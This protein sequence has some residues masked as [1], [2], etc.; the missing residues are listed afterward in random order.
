MKVLVAEPDDCTGCRYCQLW[1]SIQHYG[2]LNPF[3]SSVRIIPFEDEG[4]YVP[5]ICQQCEEAYCRVV[6]P[7]KAI[8]RNVATGAMVI[9][10]NT[11]IGC[12][13][14]MSACPFGAINVTPE[15]EVFKCDLCDGEPQCAAHCPTGAL[16]FVEKV[17]AADQRKREKAEELASTHIK[18]EKTPDRYTYG[19]PGIA[20]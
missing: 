20:P 15:G 5:G 10:K 18:K 3:K 12:R 8:D 1:C 7:A 13:A 4:L 14:C 6:C 16:Q 2:E 17:L 9:D 11:C 19:I